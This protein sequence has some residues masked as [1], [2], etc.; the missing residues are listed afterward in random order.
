[1]YSKHGVVDGEGV[2]QTT[3]TKF[4]SLNKKN[5]AGI[6]PKYENNS[7]KPGIWRYVLGT[8]GDV[9]FELVT[10]ESMRS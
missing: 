3:G 2:D 5:L 6:Y 1:M 4:F 9:S 7:I 8:S 10:G